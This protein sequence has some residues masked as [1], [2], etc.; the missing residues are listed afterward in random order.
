ML[1]RKAGKLDEQRWLH[2]MN[3]SPWEWGPICSTIKSGTQPQHS[4]IWLIRSFDTF[5]G[6]QTVPKVQKVPKHP[7]F[8]TST[9][10]QRSSFAIPLADWAMIS[11]KPGNNTKREAAHHSL[12]W[13]TPFI[14]Q[15]NLISFWVAIFFHSTILPAVWQLLTPINWECI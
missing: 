1:T 8:T 6:N 9:Y 14:S 2:L 15:V 11:I 10:I 3:S 7:L 4:Q 13:N 5:F 12:L